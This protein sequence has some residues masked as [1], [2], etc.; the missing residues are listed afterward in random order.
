VDNS[1]YPDEF[2]YG[3]FFGLLQ[4]LIPLDATLKIRYD[5]SAPTRSDGAD[6]TTYIV[7]W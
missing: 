5:M 6:V 1:P 3:M 7:S 4:R 2:Q